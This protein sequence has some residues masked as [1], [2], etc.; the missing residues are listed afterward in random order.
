[1]RTELEPL[2]IEP[3]SEVRVDPD[4]GLIDTA[5]LWAAVESLNRRMGFAPDSSDAELTPRQIRE[6]MIA[7]GIRP[8]DNEFTREL[9]RMRYGVDEE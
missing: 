2:T 8:E 1:M 5:S 4:T 6:M 3:I 9:I 7:D